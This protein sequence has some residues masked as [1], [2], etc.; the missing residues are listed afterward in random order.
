MLDL[1]FKLNLIQFCFKRLYPSDEVEEQIEDVKRKVEE[2]FEKYKKEFMAFNSVSGSNLVENGTNFDNIQPEDVTL[3]LLL[4]I[5][6]KS[7]QKLILMCS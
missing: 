4:K 5:K 2:I 3:V 7:L 6:L 1:R